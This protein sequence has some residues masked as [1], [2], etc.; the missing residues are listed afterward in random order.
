MSLPARVINLTVEEYLEM[1]AESPVRHEYVAG[2]TFAMAG[3]SD[4]HNIIAGNIFTIIRSVLRGSGCRVCL[5]EM[6]A[7]VEEI[8]AF[9]YPDVMATCEPFDPKSVFKSRPF[10]IVEVLS[11]S[12]M[13]TDRR[14]KLSAYGQLD[15]VREYVVVYQ[16]RR[17]LEVHRK[18]TQGVWLTVV[19]GENDE[20]RLDSL[21]TGP[22]TM[23]MD[24][25]YEDVT[26]V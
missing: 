2:Q 23:K 21:P 6:K 3:A 11:P 14:E 25:I 20:L 18:D 4:A 5:A 13:S 12:T 15:S 10:L 19:L 22:L 8:N 7:W 16:D 1:E 9:Y 26:F 17:R 24:E